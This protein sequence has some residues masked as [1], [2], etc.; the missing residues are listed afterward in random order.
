MSYCVVVV[1]VSCVQALW[2]L[3]LNLRVRGDPYAGEVRA[4]EDT[5]DDGI[6]EE[7]EEGAH[8][9]GIGGMG[10][11]E[12]ASV[13]VTESADGFLVVAVVRRSYHR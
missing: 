2:S 5:S 8:E 6:M 12:P 4:S 9:L 10:G 1:V 3:P 11:Q 13:S 7:E